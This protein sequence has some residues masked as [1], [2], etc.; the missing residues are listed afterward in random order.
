MEILRTGSGRLGVG[1]AVLV[2]VVT[3]SAGTGLA[4]PAQEK[5]KDWRISI[6]TGPIEGSLYLQGAAIAN[7]LLLKGVVSAAN[8]EATAGAQENVRLL[9]AGKVAFGFVSGNWVGMATKGEKPFDKK[10]DLRAVVPTQMGEEFFITL[11]NSPINTVSDL[12]G[13][14]VSVGV[15]ASGMDL[16]AQT[17]L[18]MLG[19]TYKDIQ[20]V[21]LGFGDGATALRDGN[22][23]AQLMDGLP[24]PAMTELSELADV[25]VIRYSEQD[26]QKL[27]A[28]GSYYSKFYLEKGAFRGLT[29]RTTIIAN[30]SGIVT[31]PSTDPELTYAFTKCILENRNDL[32]KKASMMAVINFFLEEAKT[33]PRIL[34]FPGAS[35]HPGS[36][37]AFKE[38]GALK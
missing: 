17:I 34:E 30:S 38:M 24:N 13:K 27:T 32:A 15:R 22:V 26:M 37:R 31:L 9:A 8:A 11:K 10:Y 1:L 33:D 3:L 21:Y 29:E 16:H 2:F 20:P 12:R 14:R 23:H 5:A 19:I 7:V 4:A 18:G 6:A 28:P 35:L 36:Y 25:K